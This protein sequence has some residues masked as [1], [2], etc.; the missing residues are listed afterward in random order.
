M[1]KPD[2]VLITLD[3]NGQPIRQEEVDTENMALYKLLKDLLIN[4]SKL[5]WENMRQIL[6]NKLER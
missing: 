2:E 3:E 6:Q 1:A 4:L 5:D